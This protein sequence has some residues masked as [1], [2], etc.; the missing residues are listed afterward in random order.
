SDLASQASLF[1]DGSQ[2]DA[3]AAKLGT[4][5]DELGPRQ[6]GD[7]F[8]R[9]A[10]AAD[11]D[12]S[13]GTLLGDDPTPA[14]AL[15]VLFGRK[16]NPRTRGKKVTCPRCGGSGRVSPWAGVIDWCEVCSGQGTIAA[17]A[18]EDSRQLR[19]LNPARDSFASV[20]KTTGALVRELLRKYAGAGFPA[21]VEVT[22]KGKTERKLVL[23]FADRELTQATLRGKQD[24][25]LLQALR[26]DL[27]RRKASV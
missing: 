14:S 3:T 20:A 17:P 6:V 27:E 26:K 9:W 11:H 15:A 19:L 12:P 8:R 10:A 21:R 13:Q 2:L 23:T 4:M 7:A 5:L 22:L 18:E 24:G 16:T 25:E 1:G